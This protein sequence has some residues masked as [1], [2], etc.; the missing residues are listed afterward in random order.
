ME[1]SAPEMGEYA[2]EYLKRLSPAWRIYL[3]VEGDQD[4]IEAITEV[5]WHITDYLFFKLNNSFGITSKATD[6]APEVGL[7]FTVP[8][9]TGP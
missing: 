8:V 4:E 2:V 1:D 9:A 6:W 5:Q 3:G 7:M